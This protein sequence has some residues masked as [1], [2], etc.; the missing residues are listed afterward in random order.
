MGW[1]IWHRNKAIAILDEVIAQIRVASMD[2]VGW[3][4]EDFI[5]TWKHLFP[6][7]PTSVRM[8]NL[9]LDHPVWGTTPNPWWKFLTN[10]PLISKIKA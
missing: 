1:A 5:A 6:I 10:A 4:N 8:G 7:T 9:P 2:I 3:F